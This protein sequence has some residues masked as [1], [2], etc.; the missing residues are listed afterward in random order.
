MVWCCTEIRRGEILILDQKNTRK[1]SIRLEALIPPSQFLPSA[2][3]PE[4]VAV[5]MVEDLFRRIVAE[6]GDVDETEV[7]NNM[8]AILNSLGNDTVSLEFSQV[9]DQ[10]QFLLVR[11]CHVW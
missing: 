11:K 1:N 10:P 7:V 4:L 8:S 6:G 5:K 9:Y 2:Q 3:L